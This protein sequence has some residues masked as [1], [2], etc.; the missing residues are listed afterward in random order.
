MQKQKI[1]TEILQ[2]FNIEEIDLQCVIRPEHEEGK[3]FYM[4]ADDGFLRDTVFSYQPKKSNSLTFRFCVPSYSETDRKPKPE[5]KFAS[6]F[7]TKKES[8]PSER[9]TPESEYISTILKGVKEFGE[10]YNVDFA[11]RGEES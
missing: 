6:L 5:I 10:Y 3:I 9:K 1:M 8:K 11:R 2:L 4:T 7:E